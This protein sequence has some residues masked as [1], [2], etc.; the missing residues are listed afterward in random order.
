MPENGW[1]RFDPTPSGERTS[2]ER[3]RVAA[4]RENGTD[5]VDAAGSEDDALATAS[6]PTATTAADD[7]TTSADG[8]STTQPDRRGYVGDLEGVNAGTANVTAPAAPESGGPSLP[9]A[10]TF[11]VWGVLAL[12]AAAGARYSGLAA[13]A[14]RA[15]WLRWL[16]RGDPR[17]EVE[18]AYERV[19]Y[20][21][22]RRHRERDRGETVRAFLA[23]VRAD[24]RARRVADLR[25]RARYA[26][27][28]DAAD[29]AE[30]KRLAR[31]LAA[32][33]SRLPG[34]RR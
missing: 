30:A 2:A 29:A 6:E 9:P 15:V 24:D 7:E 28:V 21:L 31:S 33:N 25:E 13:R 34:P 27:R 17:R 4:A 26:G 23:D 8:E 10:S 12:G 3:Q 16:P 1:V 20:L 18:G 19:E 22:E 5:G 32:E 14:Y 11:V